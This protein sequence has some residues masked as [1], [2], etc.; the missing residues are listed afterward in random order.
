MHQQGDDKHRLLQRFVRPVRCHQNLNLWPSGEQRKIW[1]GY[2]HRWHAYGNQQYDRNASE[3]Q[4]ENRK[5]EDLGNGKST[6]VYAYMPTIPF[7]QLRSELVAVC[8]YNDH[9]SV[10]PCTERK[11]IKNLGFVH[12]TWWSH[13]QHWST[14]TESTFLENARRLLLRDGATPA[15]WRSH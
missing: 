6:K 12:S 14:F 10:C 15:S 4:Y 3:C 13:T 11:N 5:K 8:L 9:Y 2:F 1:T 7:L